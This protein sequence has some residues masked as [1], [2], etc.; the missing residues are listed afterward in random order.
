MKNHVQGFCFFVCFFFLVSQS[1]AQPTLSNPSN[2]NL[3]L[4]I[5]TNSCPQNEPGSNPDVFD[6]QVSSIP[7]TLLGDDIFLRQVNLIVEHSWMGDLEM[8]LT[9]PGGISVV[10]TSY[11]GGKEDNMGDPEAPDCSGFAVLD[12]FACEAIT[13]GIPPYTDQTY[14]PEQS[15]L[16][17]NDNN[18]N[19]NGT[20]QLQICDHELANS[21]TL[22]YIELVFESLDC[23]PVQ[24]ALVANIDST[25]IIL[26]WDDA[27]C[28]NTI[29]EFGPP[30]F[31][32]GTGGMAGG[33]TVVMTDCPPYSLMDLDENTDYDI[34]IRQ[35]C[36]DSQQYSA[37]SCPLSAMTLCQPQSLT[38][39][40]TFDDE[41]DCVAACGFSCTLDGIWQ[42]NANDDFDWF[43]NTFQTITPNT[44]PMADAD[45]DGKYLYVETSGNACT[46]GA[47]AMLTSACI[48]F[49]KAGSDDCHLSFY[50]HMLGDDI[51]QLALE[52]T[53]DG[54]NWSQL[55]S[56]SGNQGNAWYKQYLALNQFVDGS[57]LQFRFVASGGNGFEGDIAIDD[58]AFYGSLNLGDPSIAY[59]VD[60]DGDGFGDSEDLNPL[61]SCYGTIPPGY[62]DNNL[63]CNDDNENINPDA[64]EI[65]CD[66]VDNNCNGMADD[67][68]L[69]PPIV[70]NDTICSGDAA[71]LM[72]MS[73]TGRPIYWYDSPNGFDGFL[74]FG[75][76]L[77]P[78]VPENMGAL[79]QEYLFYAEENGGPGCI[80][81]ERAIAKVVV[82][83]TP[84][85][86][87]ESPEVCP[88]EP[89]DLNSIVFEDVNLSGV[90]VTFHTSLP[91]NAGNQ[92]M[93][94][95]ITIAENFDVFYQVTNT[96]GCTIED[97][98]EIILKNGPD[99]S[100][101]PTSL[102]LC[103][104]ESAPVS[105]LATG[106]EEPYTYLWNNGENDAS[107]TLSNTTNPQMTQY[108]Q[109]TVTD[110]D[111][112][113]SVDS[114][115]V[116]NLPV[117]DT[118]E[119]SVEDVSACNASD[120]QI[121][122]TPQD[123]TAP[124]SYTW[125]NNNG[126]TDS[127]NSINGSMFLFD[128]E[129][130]TYDITITDSEATPCE[131]VIRVFVNGP[132]FEITGS[133]IN[134][135]SCFGG[136]DGQICVE[137]DGDNISFDWGNG[138]TDN[139]LSD[140][141]PGMYTVT[142][143][144]GNCSAVLD[145]EL[146]E[147]EELGIRQEF[148]LPS[149]GTTPDGSIDITPF[150]GTPPY[151]FSWNIGE[152]TEDLV[153]LPSGTYTLNMIDDNGCLASTTI[154]L[155][156]SEFLAI[157]LDSIQDI[158]C[159]GAG[160]GYLQ[161]SIDGGIPPYAYTWSNGSTAPAIGNLPQGDYTL[162]VTDFQDCEVVQTFSVSEPTELNVSLLTLD[163]PDCFGDKSGS[164]EVLVTGGT[165]PYTYEWSNGQD[166]AEA[167]NLPVDTY[168]LTV[169]DANNCVAEEFSAVLEATSFFELN[170]TISSPTCQGAEGGS[171]QLNP[172]GV[173]P[174]S[175]DWSTNPGEDTLS[176]VNN[177]TTGTYEVT[178]TD[179]AGCVYAEQFEVE[180]DQVFDV[181]IEVV[182]P[183]CENENN[184]AIAVTVVESGGSPFGFEWSNGSTMED[185]FGIGDGEYSL[186]I[187]DQNDC[188]FISEPIAIE[189][190][191]GLNL[192][193]E[194]IGQI[195]CN[196]DNS[197]YIEI[198]IEG[199]MPPYTYHWQ[200]AQNSFDTEDIFNLG[201]GT[202]NLTVTDEN[203]C[204]L[205]TVVILN[206]PS[207][208]KLNWTIPTGDLCD[209]DIMP[210]ICASATGGSAPYQF[211]LNGMPPTNGNCFDDLLPGEYILSVEDSRECT[212][213]ST[214]IKIDEDNP[215]VRLDTFYVE[216]ISCPGETDGSMTAIV[217][218]GSGFYEFH[219]TPTHIVQT[220][221]DS[222]RCINLASG[223]EYSV[224][225]TDLNTGCIA[226]SEILMLNDP[227]VIALERDSSQGIGCLG[228]MDGAFFVTVSGG[229]PPY[230]FEW[231]D[232]DGQLVSE[233]EDL[234]GIGGGTYT[235]DVTDDKG[236]IATFI[237][238][239]ISEPTNALAFEV[240]V[241]NVVCNG[242]ASGLIELDISGGATPY[243][244][245][246]STGN[247]E[248]TLDSLEAGIYSV[249]ITDADG[250][251]LSEEMIEI[252]EPE[253]AIQIDPDISPVSCFGFFDGQVDVAVSGGAMP[254][255]YQ[256][257]RNGILLGGE[258][259][260]ELEGVQA[261]MY[262]LRVIDENDCE[263]EFPIDITQ[264]D[265]FYVDLNV[266]FP[267]I[268]AIPQGGTPDYSYLW[269]T[270][271]TTPMLE[272]VSNGTFYEVTVTD[273]NGCE[274]EA[275]TVVTDTER[276]E[277]VQKI[278]VYPN[279]TNGQ[280]W[281]DVQLSQNQQVWV[282]LF[283]ISGKV[284][285][286]TA[287]TSIKEKRIALDLGQLE[288]GV[289]FLEVLGENGR[290]KVEQ[291]IL[292]K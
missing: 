286:E 129:Q 284:L 94:T 148:V 177:L 90:E 225:V 15:F 175:Y 215:V 3:N 72:A 140:L 10:L 123:G 47:V 30:G 39:L 82:L 189:S 281:L 162:T 191:P 32:P 264:P 181:V 217:S 6:I 198:G 20:W 199:G 68:M 139:C 121:T 40:E 65:L 292:L 116:F 218:G 161:V 211:L 174:F 249:T 100:F 107:V 5:T 147:P 193:I 134:P 127:G 157:Q 196:D 212:V 253:E 154:E 172:A 9:S 271:A 222:V 12:V 27:G 41:I 130:G 71:M 255:S 84:V 208:L 221:D 143:T 244:I 70:T 151:Q 136:S 167:I 228:S 245:E 166:A 261:G 236:C 19:P 287:P 57:I 272:N 250:C 242:E 158:S 204:P 34:Y 182:Q 133:D 178:V 24:N 184:G 13:E 120:G 112:C 185:L 50:Y 173:P 153:G 263:L 60:A 276:P 188:E 183:F 23:L 33:G 69:P 192:R 210:S 124:Y 58:I 4:P 179:G 87:V 280:I 119:I 219:F 240:A 52:V 99:L 66:F 101:S 201:A 122:L 207:E 270:G 230:Q 125:E 233:E 35:F 258:V 283:D 106:G 231:R 164:I 102:S 274:T 159:A 45:G 75:E 186:T 42:N 168:Y 36:E 194:A 252:V 285:W 150:G 165:Q 216:P 229:T 48:E 81:S 2:C 118:I 46:N 21:G 176:S 22:E 37:N 278:A 234:T 44:G 117:I 251:I 113:F 202:Y 273:M 128:L 85:V 254:Y 78:T 29:I 111:G 265:S 180:A 95:E 227:E 291:V 200:Q 155:E 224:T 141:G 197:G 86:M 31:T 137:V 61:M 160:D 26:D 241:E 73:S 108:Y 266:V 138:N 238:F 170:P 246:W 55:W 289:Y 205:D 152:N 203:N 92:I 54:I 7:G 67:G 83:P 132:G 277:L 169:T 62:S 279:P 88:G 53:N 126:N 104:S 8:I 43:P 247:T 290:L 131:T 1:I 256:W 11:N 156:S 63:D 80:S 206:E 64:E 248:A 14:A 103:Q 146:D 163:N 214:I 213:E 59:Y 56:L 209:P 267:N 171:I 135:I 220:I 262:T 243:E 232:E 226:Q 268:T 74:A 28:G 275:F 223:D 49:D 51:G 115:A 235:L 260:P 288:A 237:N 105:V 76:S 144:N 269:N 190:P 187:T 149:C 96:Y 239:E 89:F 110:A 259:F 195:A 77:N 93:N 17:F 97:Q 257:F 98:L 38:I 25:T 145:F 114:V 16:D 79:P 282:K 109:V 18:T 91:A 142:V